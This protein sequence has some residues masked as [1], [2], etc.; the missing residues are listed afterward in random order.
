[1][2]QY[3]ND[4][5]VILYNIIRQDV[6]KNN[7]NISRVQ[8]LLKIRLK[9]KSCYFNL[10]PISLLRRYGALKFYFRNKYLACIIDLRPR[11]FL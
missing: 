4:T 9:V 11:M 6:S 7:G 3:E 2:S 8:S 1:M 5:H 10:W